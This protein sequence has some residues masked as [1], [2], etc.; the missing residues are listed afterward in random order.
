LQKARLTAYHRSVDVAALSSWL[1]V[2]A[3]DYETRRL[4]AIE[5]GEPP[6]PIP[7]PVS[8][9]VDAQPAPD[10]TPPSEPVTQVPIPGRNP[11]HLPD[12]PK[13]AVPH[14]PPPVATAP[15]PNPPAPVAG[16]PQI[17]PLPPPI[18]IKPAPGAAAKPNRGRRWR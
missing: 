2:R 16:Q 18:E 11:R 4:D 5:P 8:L 12:K 13:A 9:S 3:I 6:P 17:A 7:A 10:E 15:A 1:A 14:P